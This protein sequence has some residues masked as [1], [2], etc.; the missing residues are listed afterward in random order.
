M[1]VQTDRVALERVE[2]N[3]V[4]ALD[5]AF[6]S[7]RS[8]IVAVCRS[9][10]GDDAEDAVQDAYLV[11]RSRLGQ[12]RDRER[13]AA[14]ITKIAIN[15]CFQGRRR[16]GRLM[17]LLPFLH[18]DAPVPSPDVPAAVRALPSRQ[19]TVIVLFYGHGLSVTEIAAL[20]DQKPATV[21]S[22]LF[23]ARGRLR[24]VLDADVPG[25]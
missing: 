3:D 16:Q 9:I 4:A 25:A 5:A 10:V 17:R 20:L 22:H 19:R 14:W 15:L 1:A 11:A 6:L 2:R 23:R 12:L 7:A 18:R 8:E 21:R 13:A 24:A